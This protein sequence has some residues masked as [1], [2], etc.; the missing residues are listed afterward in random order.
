MD[1]GSERRYTGHSGQMAVMSELLL[2]GYN[3]AVPEVDS[4]EGS[5]WSSATTGKKSCACR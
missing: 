5:C 3:V 4:G 2:H 1:A